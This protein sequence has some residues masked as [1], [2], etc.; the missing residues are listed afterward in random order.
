[1]YAMTLVSIP[2]YVLLL[3]LSMDSNA[4]WAA[5]LAKELVMGEPVWILLYMFMIALLSFAFSFVNVNGEEIAEKIKKEAVAYS[6]V[7]LPPEDIDAL[8]I[9]GATLT[10]MYR[11]IETLKVKAEAVIVDAM[12]LHLPVPVESMIHG[13]ARSAS[14]AAA[15]IIA[16]VHRDHIMDQYDKEYPGYGFASNKGYGTAEHI[17]AIHRLGITPIHRKSFEPVKSMVMKLSVK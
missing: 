6:I 1:M 13:D 11:A 14:V 10:A 15:S 5:K 16:K 7:S 4:K 3:V 9:Y 17:E 12:P 2:Q 8:N